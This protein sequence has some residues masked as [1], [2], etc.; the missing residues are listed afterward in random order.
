M[1]AAFLLF[2][3]IA[4]KKDAP[5]F[6]QPFGQKQVHQSVETI[7]TRNIAPVFHQS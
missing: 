5:V 1:A 6:G 2:R 3:L 4:P 7:Q